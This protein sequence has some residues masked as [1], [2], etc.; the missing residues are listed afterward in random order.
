MPLLENGAYMF[1]LCRNLK[2]F[3]GDLSSLIDGYSMFNSCDLSTFSTSNLDSLI[4]GDFMFNDCSLSVFSTSMKSLVSAQ[5]MFSSNDLLTTFGSDLTS[6]KNGAFMFSSCTA[7]STFTSPSLKNLLSGYYMFYGC[8]LNS[9]SLTHIANVIND[10]SGLDKNIEN[11]WKY[12][13]HG[14]EYT[15]STDAR[16]TMHVTVASSVTAAQKNTFTSSMAAKGWNVI[17]LNY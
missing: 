2:T 4:D 15:M 12:I 14:Q 16:G 11:N 10:I 17:F 9:S 8:K 6:L 7:L 5:S 3:S 1:E 13:S